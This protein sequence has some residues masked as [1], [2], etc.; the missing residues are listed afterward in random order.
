MSD[1]LLRINKRMRRDRGQAV[2]EPSDPRIKFVTIT[3]VKI[4][5]AYVNVLGDLHWSRRH[6]W[7]IA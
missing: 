2:A 7:R 1:R 5:K 3:G 6:T 4:A